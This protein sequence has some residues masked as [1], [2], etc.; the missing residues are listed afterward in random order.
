MN[1]S[2]QAS[3]SRGKAPK[4]SS[5]ILPTREWEEK[6][7][8]S[9]GVVAGMDE[10]GRGSLAGPVC[11]GLAFAP[12]AGIPVLPGLADSKM[13]SLR[14]REAL[15]EPVFQW[16][17]CIEI[18]QASNDEI[19]R[20][21]IIAALRLA[22]R[23]ALKAASD[24]GFY[25]DLVILDGSQDW[26]SDSPDLFE[27]LDGPLYPTVSTPKVLTR[28][29]ADASCATVSAASVAAKVFRDRLMEEYEDPGY[30]WASNK[31]YPSAAHIDALKRLGPSELHRRSWRLP[32]VES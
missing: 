16:S 21:G 8:G 14:A 4:R 26:L 19:D 17:P 27:D 18:G 22:G 7:Q 29:K 12:P 30:G 32:G 9:F 31:G 10:V 28:V 3:S 11:V 15:Y 23:R 1:A 6:L 2:K 25:A 24:R 20:Y 5:K 13:L